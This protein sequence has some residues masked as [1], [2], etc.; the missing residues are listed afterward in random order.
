MNEFIAKRE[1]ETGRINPMITNADKWNG[2]GKAFESSEEAYNSMHIGG[3]KEA[4]KLQAEKKD[5]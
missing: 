2:L 4:I 3:I 5:K 1:K